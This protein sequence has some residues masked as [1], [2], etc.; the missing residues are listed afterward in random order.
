MADINS[1]KVKL[2]S[3]YI[4]LAE[5]FGLGSAIILTILLA[6]LFFNLVLFYLRESDN[7]GYLSFGS[8]GLFAFL[9]SFPYLLIV[10]LILL[11]LLAGFIMKKSGM[12]YKKPFGYL[13][14]ALTI[15]IVLAGMVLAYT[16]IAQRIERESR[17]SHTV[18]RFFKPFFGQ[19]SG[20][21]Q[22]GIAGRIVEIAG[23]NI[24]IQTPRDTQLIDLSLDTKDS[25]D[26]LEVGMF[27]MAVG[28]RTPEIFKAERIRV[29]DLSEM[30]MVQRGVH[31]RF[32]DVRH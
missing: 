25:P 15:F 27:I 23:L 22:L 13:A 1:G 6:V 8:R 11:V 9:E 18:G 31:E 20:E 10:G 14:L 7:L 17:G 28:V 29:V 4:F 2:R 5:K 32:G 30:P 3:K 21:R 12:N 24:V 26:D 16:N 19:G